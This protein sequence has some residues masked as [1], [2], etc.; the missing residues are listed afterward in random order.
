MNRKVQVEVISHRKSG[1][2]CINTYFFFFYTK[3]HKLKWRVRL[4][5]GDW[6]IN[7]YITFTKSY[8]F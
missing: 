3:R 4:A 1:I 6:F 5:K 8:T 2:Y 7:I